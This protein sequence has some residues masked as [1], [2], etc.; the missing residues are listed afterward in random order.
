MELL[1]EPEVVESI[2]F[3]NGTNFLKGL[4]TGA[5]I[6]GAIGAVSWG[7]NKL[8]TKPDISEDYYL[9]D[10]IKNNS[11]NGNPVDKRYIDKYFNENFN[12][13]EKIKLKNAG[14][15]NTYFGK[16][17]DSKFAPS[18]WK[19]NS[20]GA[21]SGIIEGNEINALGITRGGKIYLAPKALSNKKLF[22]FTFHHELGHVMLSD[23]DEY[24]HIA[25]VG[26][27]FASHIP[28]SNLEN[29]FVRLNGFS[30]LN[31]QV[32]QKLLNIYDNTLKKLDHCLS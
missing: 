27:D 32:N 21:F 24:I 8:F 13:A 3:I 4:A 22:S 17:P 30:N 18:G 26:K 28:I 11:R 9:E 12:D 6:G 29:Q 16:S 1:P 25:F 23:V 20:E 5:V 2:R 10:N 7:L 14:Y 19:V 31:Y 15:K